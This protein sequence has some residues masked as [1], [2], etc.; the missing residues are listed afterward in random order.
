MAGKN[1]AQTGQVT[2]PKKK[3]GG[4]KK[5]GD[6][7]AEPFKYDEGYTPRLQGEYDKKVVSALR[8][9]FKHPNTMMT[10]RL[11]KVVVNMGLGEAVAN[12]KIIDSAVEDMRLITG[13]APV[14]RRARKS[15]AGFKL[16]EGLAIG[17]KVT[18][19]RNKMWEFVDRLFNIALPR[20]RDFKGVS[21]KGFD[22]RG[23]YTMGI[24]EQIIFPEIDYDKVD[25]VRGMNISFVTNARTN[26]EGRELLA[27][28]G[29]PFRRTRKQQEEAAAKA[30]EAAKVKTNG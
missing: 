2:K 20:V 22:G 16:R 7:K 10:P 1:K 15:I 19:R 11:K 14:V 27:Q 29:M 26:E 21:P 18:L 24:K 9:K 30:K 17:V 25:S 3:G 28:L 4:K 6:A 5:K 23:N 8:E 13:Q 12:P